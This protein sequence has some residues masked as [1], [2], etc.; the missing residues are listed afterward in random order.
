MQKELTFFVLGL[1]LV[2]VVQ[3]TALGSIIAW[4][5]AITNTFFYSSFTPS[6][7]ACIP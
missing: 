4:E 7:P 1:V 3:I 5:L 2:M 6:F